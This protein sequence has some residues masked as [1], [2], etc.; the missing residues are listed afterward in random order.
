M[1]IIYNVIIRSTP[2]TANKA[3]SIH[4]SRLF[5]DTFPSYTKRLST[6]ATKFTTIQECCSRHNVGKNVINNCG[7]NRQFLLPFLN[8]RNFLG[9]QRFKNKVEINNTSS[10]PKNEWAELKKLPLV[11]RLHVMFKKYWYIA[12]PFHCVNCAVWFASFFLLAQL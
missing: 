8:Q 9:T 4:L 6:T 7:R 1:S 2:I 12:I 5:V 10:Q 11:K 3:S